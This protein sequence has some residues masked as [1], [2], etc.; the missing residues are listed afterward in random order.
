MDSHDNHDCCYKPAAPNGH[1]FRRVA[2]AAVSHVAASNA[3]A[4]HVIASHVA[5][6]HVVASHMTVSH[7]AASH[8]V[9]ILV[10]ANP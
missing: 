9:E 7:A 10:A 4:S 2:V 8:V 3:M 6:S 1:D 5:A